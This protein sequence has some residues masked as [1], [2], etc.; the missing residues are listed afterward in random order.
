MAPWGGAEPLIGTNPIAFAIPAGEE[1]PVVL[2]IATSVSSFGYIREHALQGKPIPE[3]WVIDRAG[4]PITDASRATEGTLLPIGGYKGAGLALII[5]LLA[6]VLNG[7]AFGRDVR[8]FGTAATEEANT[9]QFVIALDV[10]RFL[11][12]AAFTAEIDRHIREFRASAR[13]PGFDAIRIPGEARRRRKE[14]RSRDGVALT[15]ALLKQLDDLAAKLKLAPLTEYQSSCPARRRGP[16]ATGRDCSCGG[17]RFP[18]TGHPAAFRGGDPSRGRPYSHGISEAWITSGTPWP[19]T[20]RMAR[21]TSFSPKRW[22][23]TF[24]SGKRFEASCASASSQ[25]L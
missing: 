22:V 12:L 7:G 25:A 15:P 18:P 19:P 21:S 13:L 4:Q 6:G 23:V 20:E 14:E 10:A 8:D 17:H 24:S 1:A 5:G 2:D 16:I 9:G 11:P 3:G